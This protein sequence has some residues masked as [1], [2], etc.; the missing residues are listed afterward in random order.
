MGMFTELEADG[1][2]E[3]TMVWVKLKKDSWRLL[4]RPTRGY[5]L[6]LDFQN[7]RWEAKAFGK[8]MYFGKELSLDQVK[9]T[10]MQHFAQFLLDLSSDV[11]HMT[12]CP[13]ADLSDSTAK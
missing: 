13:D 12:L 8:V 1:N 11:L 9:R 2:P 3:P 7:E 5:I 10:A 6:N 4:H